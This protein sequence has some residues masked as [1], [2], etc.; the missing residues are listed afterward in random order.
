MRE[1]I[2]ANFSKKVLTK[3]GIKYNRCRSEI[4]LGIGGDEFI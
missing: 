2:F 4:S 3:E 1:E